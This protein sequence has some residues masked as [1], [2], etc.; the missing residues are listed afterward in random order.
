MTRTPDQASRDRIEAAARPDRPTGSSDDL[1]NGRTQAVL[2]M[3]GGMFAVE[4]AEQARAARNVARCAPD[5]AGALG[6]D[7]P[8]SEPSHAQTFMAIAARG[9]KT[10]ARALIAGLDREQISAIRAEVRRWGSG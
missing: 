4:A 2:S 10:A 5:L 1:T 6:L 8:D 7:L 9:D 3:P